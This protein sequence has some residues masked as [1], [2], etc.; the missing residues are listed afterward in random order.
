MHHLDV[1][2]S[3]LVTDPVAACLAVALGGHALEDILDGAPGGLVTTGHQRRAVT[4]TLLT[5]GN[6]GADEVQTLGLEVLS[7]AVGVGEVRV[8]TIND[9]VSGLEQGQEGLD[10]VVD[11]LSSLHE[12]H[13][14]A[15]RLELGDELLGGVSTDD[16]LAL[17]LV[18]KET[19]DLGDCSVESAN[20]EAVVGHVQNQVLTPERLLAP[21]R[22]TTRNVGLW[23]LT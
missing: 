23:R 10:P 5:S 7:S 13:D 4:G 6:T 16:G 8:S 9:D 15:R 12:K 22:F 17:G 19:V 3:T 14:T 11:G 21:R 18:L 2:A 20:G 1:V